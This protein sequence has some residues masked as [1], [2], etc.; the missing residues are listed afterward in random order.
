[1]SKARPLSK[2]SLAILN[3]CRGAT[4]EKPAPNI[5]F[6][7]AL[8][9]QDKGLLDFRMFDKKLGAG[10]HFLTDAGHEAL[11]LHEGA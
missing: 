9:L 6:W 3:A 5:G 2:R 1:M 10:G 11:R 7:H 4:Y 8:H